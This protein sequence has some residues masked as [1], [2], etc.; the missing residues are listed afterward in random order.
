[1]ALPSAT[2]F[3]TS[4]APSRSRKRKSGSGSIRNG[5]RRPAISYGRPD[6]SERRERFLLS[7]KQLIAGNELIVAPV[8]L[9]PIMARLAE[10]AGFKALY[11][12][13]GSLGW[14]TCVTEANLSVAEMVAAVVE[15]RTV[16][17]LP[18]VVDVGGGWGD[19]VH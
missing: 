3:A 18:V 13:G 10:D 12:S 1:M 16:C 5:N 7:L 15:M 14:L 4:R 8:A 19:P 2:W 6:R 9:N 11:L 17:K